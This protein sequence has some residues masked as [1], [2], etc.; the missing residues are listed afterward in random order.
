MNKKIL[1]LILLLTPAF[2]FAQQIDSDVQIYNEVR[3]SFNNGFYPG[4]VTS[5]ELLQKEYPKSSFLHS[6]L[7]YKGEALIN[8]ESYED[9]IEALEDAVAYMHSGSPEIIRCN[10]LLGRALFCQKKY[11]QALEKFYR[12]CSLSLTNEDMEFYPQSLL[13]SGRA[14][15]ELEE[16]KEAIPLFEYVAANGNAF[17]AAEYGEA[18][19]KLF[20]CYNKSGAPEKTAALFNKFSKA[21]F[22]PAFEPAIY[23][24]LCF[25]YG[26]ACAALGKNEEAYEAYS[27]VLE[28][29]EKSLAVSALK[30]AYLISSENG[31]ADS[32]EVLA[33]TQEAFSDKPEFLNEFWLR[34]AIDEF[35]AKNYEKAEGYL[36]NVEVSE[37]SE[38]GDVKLFK[39]LYAAKI[40]LEKGQP[41]EAEKMLSGLES[42]AKK[43]EAE[44]AADSYY[45]TL[46]QCKLQCEKWDEVP[47]V[48]SKLKSPD[49]NAVFALST[50]YYKKGQFDKVDSSCGELYASAL[51][52]SGHYEE[53]CLEYAKLGKASQDYALALFYCGRYSDAEKIAAASDSPQKDYLCGL[54]LINQKAWKTAADRFASYIRTYSNSSDF[55][56]LSLYYKGYA[57]YNQAE[58]KNSY[59][60][61][62]RFCMEAQN[63]MESSTGPYVLR[64]YEYAVKSALQ[65]GDFKNASQQAA[66]LVRYSKEGEEKQKA[67]ILSAEIFT[68]YGSYTEAIDLLAP[69]TSGRDDFAAQTLFMTA[70]I[71]ERQ[72]KVSSA[73]ELY[74][75]IY[76]GLPRSSYVEEAMYRAGEAFYSHGDYSS[77]YTRFNNYIYKYASGK[78]SDAAIF[79]GGDCALRLGENDRCVMLN[80]TLLQKYPSSVYAYGANKNLLDA[81]YRQE[82]YSQALSVAR[83]ILRDF[84]QQ[85]GDDEIGKRVNELEK[86]VSGTDRRVAEKESEYL[87]L[88]EAST[89]AGRNAGTELVKLYAESLST[90][91]EAYELAEKLFARQSGA[92]ERGAAA[93]NA[94]FIAEYSRRNGNNKKA[95]EMYLKAAEYYRSVKNSSG[96]ASALY[97]AAEA[98]A[99]EGLSGD[100][101]ETAALLKE[102]Y[103]SSLQ[104]ERVDRVTGDARN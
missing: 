15:Y 62:V 92:E 67:V 73:D 95:A 52:K 59:S 70:R 38:A 81:Y 31:L 68:D 65:S 96:A 11:S 42:L 104:A 69:Y 48:Y 53:A 13:Y 93:Y 17:D 83:T 77:A 76:E 8:M 40:L 33:R 21:D 61:F 103:P 54:C 94:E 5:A 24:T 37:Y 86:I 19:Q 49:K 74:R 64:A 4:A 89:V 7:A 66:N 55:K 100:A 78:F 57:E 29:G 10:Y 102:L 36:S 56:K 101:R 46:L 43:S 1:A 18:L 79:Y 45:S 28:S 26:D 85:A 82:N 41:A 14:F 51:C 72:D 88:G 50:Y 60:S 22:E 39:N 87:R 16:W 80:M 75:R 23:T 71:Y 47:G 99:A 25:Y 6:A 63:E 3:Q 12:A 34:L 90:Q 91:T 27:Q 2:C 30:K 98:F 58:F 20:I 97:G 32:G 84:P 9:A 44:A 35:N